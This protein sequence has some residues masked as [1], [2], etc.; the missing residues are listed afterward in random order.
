MQAAGGRAAGAAADEMA[1]SV[2]RIGWT[3]VAAMLALDGVPIQGCQALVTEKCETLFQERKN[4]GYY[5]I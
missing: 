5:Y 1:D 4:F 2:D 3:L